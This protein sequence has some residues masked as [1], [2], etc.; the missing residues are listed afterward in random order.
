MDA[1]MPFEVV[2]YRT[3]SGNE[4]VHAWLQGLSKRDKRMIGGDIKTVPY[5]WLLGMPVVR[6]IE[7]RL[8]EVKRV[9]AFQLEVL[10]KAQKL[11][12]PQ[13]ARRMKTSRSA[14]ERLL[15]PNNP[16]VTLL[17]LKNMDWNSTNRRFALGQAARVSKHSFR[18]TGHLNTT[19]RVP[20]WAV[21]CFW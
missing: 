8:W 19:S 2:F 13:L 11:S 7:P 3:E 10:M 17:T 1:D 14:L 9:L 16:S 12:K 15:D 5:G 20:D 21:N 4:P 18:I 6:K